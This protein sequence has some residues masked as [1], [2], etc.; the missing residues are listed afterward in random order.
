MKIC[1]VISEYDPFHNG[2]KYMLEQMRKN[3]ATHIVA[4]MSGN[5]TQRGDF[6]VYDKFT[7]ARTALMNG[8][9]LVA[10]LPVTYSCSC[11]EHFAFGGAYILNAFGCIDSLYF[12]SESGN[13]DVLKSICDITESES[14]KA[15][16]KKNLEEGMSFAAAREKAVL[17]CLD[18]GSDILR[19]PNNILGI[20]YIKAL[21]K[22]NSSIHANTILRT[23]AEHDSFETHSATAS[24]SYIR[25]LIYKKSDCK[26]YI[27]KNTVSVLSQ[28]K[29]QPPD[30][31]RIKNMECAVLYRLRMM[32]IRDFSN[33]PDISEGLENRLYKAVRNGTSADEIMR[34]TKCKR[35]TMSRIRRSI[36]HSFLGITKS[37]YDILPKYIRV[38]GFNKRGRE[39]LHTMRSVCKLPVIMR[40]ADI[41]LCDDDAK[42]I[43]ELESRCDDIFSISGEKNFAC[44]H[45]YTENII[46]L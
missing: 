13:I 8:A 22:L 44:G 17:R 4:C 38:L 6:A 29:N 32:D 42:K 23:G 43:F 1:A 41:R 39:I 7:R 30:K 45:N 26:R 24:A 14:I 16:I 31:P 11:A 21:R 27:P 3:G 35:Y 10:E 15:E 18:V 46:I 34:L 33:L 36:V 28:C 12:G 40:Y 19:K 25:E 20:E 37:D 9:D 2:H 5:F